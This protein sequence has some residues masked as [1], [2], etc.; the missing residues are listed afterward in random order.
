MRSRYSRFYSLGA[1][2]GT[3][4]RYVSES[5]GISGRCVVVEASRVCCWVF[6]GGFCESV[7][8][9][10]GWFKWGGW[11]NNSLI[12]YKFYSYF[13]KDIWMLFYDDSGI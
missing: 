6:G 9:W 12:C 4:P 8:C 11:A 10:L 13:F 2:A 3:G 1:V 5:G 7:V